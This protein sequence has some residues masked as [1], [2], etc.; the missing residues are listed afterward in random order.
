MAQAKFQLVDN[1]VEVPAPDELIA[2]N[3]GAV[4]A[5][6]ITVNAAGDYKRGQAMMSASGGVF[7]PV[8]AAGIAGAAEVCILC[9]DFSIAENESA[10]VPAYFTGDFNA[11]K[12]ILPDGVTIS[13]I[14]LVFRKNKLFLRG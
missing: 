11:S 9:K 3:M 13:D 12:V 5:D 14:N 8:T 1:S 2:G 10:E 7:T 6:K 4:F